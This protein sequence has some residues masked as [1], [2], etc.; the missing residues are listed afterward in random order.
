MKLPSSATAD[1]NQRKLTEAFFPDP[2]KR[3][4]N[5]DQNKRQTQFIFIRQLVVW[6]CRDLLP[7]QTVCRPGFKEFWEQ[8]DSGNKKLPSR[9]T[10]SIKGL[11]DVYTCFKDRLIEKLAAAPD[12]GTM[13]S[14]MWTDKYKRTSYITYT[15]HYMSESWEMKSAVLEV[16]KF[17]HPHTGKRIVENFKSLLCEFKL[18]AKKMTVVTDGESAME[19]A[20][21]DLKLHRL[22]CIAHRIHLLLCTDLLKHT[23][24]KRLE[25]L[26][27]KLRNIRT[28][29]IYRHEEL[30]KYD[31]EEKQKQLFKAV[32]EFAE[33][34]EILNQ[35]HRFYDDINENVIDLEPDDSLFGAL[36]SFSGISKM[37]LTR[38][39]SIP[40]MGRSHLK[41]SGKLENSLLH[42]S[43]R[44]RKISSYLQNAY[45]VVW[46]ELK[47]TI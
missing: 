13:T 6:I 42:N 22:H 2:K 47:N 9:T 14:D 25:P 27:I 44:S 32:V 20:C 43:S 46:K 34:E 19:K 12:H 31:D 21:K 1:K 36:Q 18:A 17:E 30:K 4:P 23:N 24:S 15:Y 40:K 39:N 8:N 26:F 3:K 10:I 5:M 35:E 29:L 38:W 37:V 28:A 11:N 7:Y 45:V 16:A 41:Y 33:A